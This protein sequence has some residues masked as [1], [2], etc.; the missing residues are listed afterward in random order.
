MLADGLVY[1]SDRLPVDAILEHPITVSAESLMNSVGPRAGSAQGHP[2]TFSGGSLMDSQP[3]DPQLPGAARAITA[4]GDSIIGA[5]LS[6]SEATFGQDP[7]AQPVQY[8]PIRISDPSNL[9]GSVQAGRDVNTSFCHL[10][11]LPWAKI[12][13]SCWKPQTSIVL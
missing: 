6:G 12:S 8:H 3:L 10:S 11:P 4:S 1:D 13:A 9:A 2:I 7:Q 5:S